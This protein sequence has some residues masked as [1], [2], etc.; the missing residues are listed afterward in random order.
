M[1]SYV[2]YDS[3]GTAQ[4]SPTCSTDNQYLTNS[5]CDGLSAGCSNA[6]SPSTCS[7]AYFLPNSCKGCPGF[8]APNAQ[9]C[10][11]GFSPSACTQPCRPSE[12]STPAGCLKCDPSCAT[13]TA[14]MSSSA[15]G[16]CAEGYTMMG[17]TCQACGLGCRTC[18]G[19]T[20]LCTSCFREAGYTLVGGKCYGRCS[21]SGYY[22]DPLLLSCRPCNAPCA[23]CASSPSNCTMCTS[24]SY[25]TGGQCQSCSPSC[26][27]C[28]ATASACITCSSNYF[29]TPDRSCVGQCADVAY[30]A[31]PSNP[32]C[33]PCHPDCQ[34]CVSHPQNCIACLSDST[35]LDGSLGVNVCTPCQSPCRTCVSLSDCLS[36][37]D[38]S[39]LQGGSCVKCDQSCLT[40]KGPS[41]SN[42]LSCFGTSSLSPDGFCSGCS[43]SCKLCSGSLCRGC[44]EGFFLFTGNCV[45]VCPS[46]TFANGSVC[47][48]C[49]ASCSACNAT[50]CL[51]CNTGYLYTLGSKCLNNCPAGYAA[52]LGTCIKTLPTN[53]TNNNG[54]SNGNNNGNNSGNNNNSNGNG[55]NNPNSNKTP[56]PNGSHT[57]LTQVGSIV[58]QTVIVQGR[59]AY[60]NIYFNSTDILA[61][62]I[63]V[64]LV[65]RNN[66]D[67]IPLSPSPRD[68]TDNRISFAVTL[69]EGSD[70]TQY[71]LIQTTSTAPG[72][73]TSTLLSSQSSNQLLLNDLE[74]NAFSNMKVLS[75]IFSSVVLL[76]ALLSKTKGHFTAEE[77]NNIILHSINFAQVCYLFKFTTTLTEGGY[78]FLNGFGIASLTFF[79]NFFPPPDYYVETPMEKSL[80]PDGNLLRNAGS[81]MSYQLVVMGVLLVAVVSSFLYQKGKG[82]E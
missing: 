71:S 65:N 4:C 53:S 49:D 17:R 58:D 32:W 57:T 39:Y 33:L 67:V 26:S 59:T 63:S 8:C 11:A 48:G 10:I 77:A 81:S 25:R 2:R 28:F 31:L 5:C 14:P 43:S 42:C 61:N 29:M 7:P 52:T 20:D 16:N 18:S 34:G 64:N 12:V 56:T 66:G 47:S 15:C 69:P 13:C 27:T 74:S 38:G 75:Y 54:N 80:V 23:E 35:Y 73:T 78:F 82:L 51:N 62:S 9:A 36:C 24:P 1:G 76:Y 3:S 19:A 72:G 41:N 44:S 21:N 68:V 46:G 37:V 6:Y 45:V 30:K 55:N 22:L 70:L 50:S 60:I 40:C 79:P